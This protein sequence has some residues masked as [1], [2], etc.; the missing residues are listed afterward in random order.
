MEEVLQSCLL[1]SKTAKKFYKYIKNMPIFDY[2]CHITAEEIYQ[3][4]P[5]K[6][7][8]EIWLEKDHYKWRMMRQ[9]GIAEQNITGKI[10]DYQKFYNFASILPSFA[11]NPVYL[12]VYF[13]LKKYFGIDCLLNDKNALEVWAKTFNMLK[14]GDFTPRK[15]IEM[16]NVDCLITTDDPTSD[17]KYHKLLRGE[18]TKFKVLPCIRFDNLFNIESEQ[19]CDYIKQLEKIC[20]YSIKNFKTLLKAV[21]GRTEYFCACGSVSCDLSLQN[22][23]TGNF[24]TSMATRVFEKVLNREKIDAKNFDEYKLCLLKEIAFLMRKN[25]MVMQIHIG[26]IRNQNTKKFNLLGRDCG[27]DSIANA[28]DIN[29]MGR[30]LDEVEKYCGLPKTICYAH[31]AGSY[32][33]LSTMLGNF[34][35]EQ[36]GKLQLGCAWWMNDNKEGI[37]YQLKV[38]AETNGLGYFN[39]MLTDSRSVTSFVRHDYFRRILASYFAELVENGEYIFDLKEIKKQLCNIAYYNAKRYFSREDK[40]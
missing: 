37:L 39:G 22:I 9:A 28:V 4:K 31:N 2:H 6:N 1:K 5:Y 14:T 17:L 7:L 3:N 19:F 34:S 11:G 29:A 35:C 30:F 26:A 18:K 27:C 12:W 21:E 38:F 33:A 32:Y 13:E 20:G 25:N 15:I 24:S 40:R 10:D 36:K 23:P 16:S 8:S